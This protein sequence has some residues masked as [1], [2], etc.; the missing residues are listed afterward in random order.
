MMG[1]KT[2]KRLYKALIYALVLLMSFA[3]LFPLLWLVRSSFM[4]IAQIFRMPPQWVP[5][6]FQPQNY[7]KAFTDVPFGRYFLNT[8][9]I[10]AVNLAAVLVVTPLSAYGFARFRWRGRDPVFFALLCSMMLPASVSLI[11]MFLFWNALKLTGSFWPLLI[12]TWFGGGVYNIFL[13]RQFM[14]T[15]PRQLDESAYLDGAN[16]FVILVR[17]IMP[18]IKPALITIGLFCFLYHWNDYLTPVIYLND[19][20]NFTISIGLQQFTSMYSAQ[21]HLLMA[22]SSICVIPPI[23]IFFVGQ[24]FF[25]EGITIT[26]I[27]G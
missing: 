6:P 8:F 12:P 23:M 10:I 27:K 4:S 25:I 15:I 7:V 5:T 21:W 26:G 18:L 16:S 9:L 24:K 17:I 11:P 13:L 14:M 1:A 2:K 20:N 19:I 3:F 22:A